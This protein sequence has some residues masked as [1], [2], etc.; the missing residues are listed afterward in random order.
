MVLLKYVHIL[1]WRFQD[2]PEKGGRSA[3]PNGSVGWGG[4]AGLQPII[5]S[6][7]TQ[8]KRM[9]MKQIGPWGRIRNPPLPWYDGIF[10][11]VES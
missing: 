8:I 1:Q 6:N 5:R 3:K 9:K 2:F 4:W 10:I 11:F 7:V